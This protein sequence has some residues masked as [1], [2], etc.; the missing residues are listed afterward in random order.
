MEITKEDQM[1]IWHTKTIHAFSSQ[2]FDNIL[3]PDNIVGTETY[4]VVGENKK[5]LEGYVLSKRHKKD[6]T[7]TMY[8][9]R[10]QDVLNLPMRIGKVTKVHSK[11][12][13]YSL[14]NGGVS[15]KITPTQELSWRE[16]IDFSGIPAHTNPI[17][18]TLYKNKVLY[19]RTKGQVFFRTITESAFGKDKYHEA[20]RL[21]MH[22]MCNLSD[23]TTAKLFYA[24]CHNTDIRINELPESGTKADFIKLCNAV[25]R[26][27]DA[28]TILD[29]RSRKTEGTTEVAHIEKLSTSFTHNVPSYYSDRG[30]Q[31][32]E[33]IFPYNV[34]NRYYYNLYEGFLEASFPS[35][36]NHP[37]LAE[38][39]SGFIKKWIKSVLWY[40]ENWHRLKNLFP[41]VDLTQYSFQKAENRFKDHLIDFA[42]CLSHYAKDETEYKN[43]LDVEYASHMKYRE[44]IGQTHLEIHPKTEEVMMNPVTYDMFIKKME[45]AKPI[46]DYRKELGLEE[47]TFDIYLKKALSAGDCFESG[48]GVIRRLD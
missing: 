21:L 34:V 8:F 29:N 48:P 32:F 31:T 19:S 20:V 26:I 36:L 11:G 33:E 4:I 13:V 42:R 43:L 14:L 6:S 27:G 12:N 17:H 28:S 46:D 45:G 2:N 3:Y 30:H 18:H 10:T 40:E 35:D 24:A 39:Y 16:C 9:L 22:Q 38:K 5:H 7:N 23:P 15:V 44:L 41:N 47:K 37:A 25:I 1:I